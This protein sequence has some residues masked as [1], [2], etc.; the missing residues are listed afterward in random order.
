MRL[1]LQRIGPLDEAQLILQKSTILYGPN[2]SGKTTVA[3]A[4]GL[5]IK[6]LRGGEATSA[7]ALALISRGAETGRI[8]LDGYE[9]EL[10]RRPRSAVAVKIMK[11]GE[12][13]YQR[14]V[15][16]I[17][18]T[19]LGEQPSV[20]VL[21]RVRLGD[22]VVVDG[23]TK[24]LPLIELASPSI[25]TQWGVEGKS[26]VGMDEYAEYMGEVNDILSGI[27]D[28]ELAAV[29]DKLYYRSNGIHFDEENTAA[30]IQRV[31]LIAAAYALAKKLSERRGASPLLFI[32]NFETALHLD[33]I[34]SLLRFLASSEIPTVVETHSGLVLR[35]AI[36]KQLE[37]YVFA[38]GT[39]T[40]DLKTLEL[41]WRE[42]QIMAELA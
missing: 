22:V 31:A 24:T 12:V 10:T 25:V 40:K 27:T 39:A 15:S 33:Y 4:L 9:V 5:V 17:I 35:T 29:E 38:N 6:L 41:F 26:A 20:G 7:E 16:G 3:R 32:E 21:L 11:T 37:Y 23:E 1:F 18:A 2:G 13:L 28:H 36:L 8:S 19:G 34:V 14:E 42:V 30:G